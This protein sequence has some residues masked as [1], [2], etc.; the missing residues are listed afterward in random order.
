[1]FGVKSLWTPVTGCGE[2]WQRKGGAEWREAAGRIWHLP[3]PDMTHRG[4]N[5]ERNGPVSPAFRSS[6]NRLEGQ[7]HEVSRW[8]QD[9]RRA[10]ART[11]SQSC[12]PRVKATVLF[13]STPTPQTGRMGP[14]EL[15]G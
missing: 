15:T 2:D 9:S 12:F 4:Y 7:S 14:F 5:E 3:V 11:L 1:M 6:Q 10:K 13:P 8:N